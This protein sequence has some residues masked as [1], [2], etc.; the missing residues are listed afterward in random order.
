MSI[1]SSMRVASSSA[2]S[3]NETLAISSHH[4]S[5]PSIASASEMG[6][7]VAEVDDGTTSID[8]SSPP[9][10]KEGIQLKASSFN[11]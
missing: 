4:G 10:I 6:T 7:I 1:A 3:S 5:A 11:A 8:I 9:P 2:K